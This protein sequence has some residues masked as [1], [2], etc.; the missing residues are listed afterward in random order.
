MSLRDDGKYRCDGMCESPGVDVENAGVQTCAIISDLDP[1]DPTRP[2]VLHLC[3]EPR[4]GAPRGCVGLSLG[5]GTL[6]NYYETRTPQ[7]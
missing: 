1:D 3:R 4:Q 7:A 5:P 6:K 2:R